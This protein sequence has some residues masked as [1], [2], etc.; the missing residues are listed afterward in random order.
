MRAALIELWPVLSDIY[1]LHPWDV[2]RLSVVELGRYIDDLPEYPDPYVLIRFYL[3]NI[4]LLRGKP[5]LEFHQ[6]Q[7]F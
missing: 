2:H 5:L 1:G 3:G 4:F 6:N 7:Q